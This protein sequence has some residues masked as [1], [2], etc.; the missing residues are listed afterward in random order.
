MSLLQILRYPD[1][2]LNKVADP[3]REVNESIRQLVHDMTETLYAAPGIGL[4]ASQVDVHKQ[5]IVIDVSENKDQLLVLINPQMLESRGSAECEEG[6]LSVP[7][8]FEKLTRAEW[9]RIRALD[10]NGEPFEFEATGLLAVCVQH[11]ID[12]LKGRVFVDYLSRLKQERIIKK[13]KKAE[14]VTL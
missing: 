7:G 1:A 12:H 6:C 9:V 3:V 11:E 5:V 14:R 8:I 13:L 10:T 2:R 4:A